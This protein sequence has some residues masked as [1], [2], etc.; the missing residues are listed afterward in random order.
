MKQS[1]IALIVAFILSLSLLGACATQSRVESLEEQARRDRAEQRKIYKQME[2]ELQNRIEQSSSPVRE[3]Q[4]DIWVEMNALR[5]DVAMLQGQVDDLSLRMNYLMGDGNSTATLPGLATDMDA[6]KFALEHQLAIDLQKITEQMSSAKPKAPAAIAVQT[7]RTATETKPEIAP[8][9]ETE[10]TKPATLD[11]AQA[12]YDKAYAE[13]GQRKYEEAR[14]IWAEFVTAYKD[15]FLVPNAIFWQGEC[16]Y[17][18]QDY[19]RAVLA[20]QDVIKKY[21]KSS[22]Y[23]YSLLKQGISFYKMGREDLGK[24]VL[25]DLIDKYPSTPEAA[26]AEQFIQ[27]G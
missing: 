16:Y 11:P 19:K 4:A 22:K 27:G 2:E 14:S 23:K 13:F 7:A 21:P 12:L 5:A 6:V 20:Y 8:A 17:Q 15:H 18:L 1:R 10:A 9:G 3:K 25:Q 24:V 26:R